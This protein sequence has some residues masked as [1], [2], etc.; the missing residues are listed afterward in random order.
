MQT[1]YEFVKLISGYAVARRPHGEIE[2]VY[3]SYV[4]A[5]RAACEMSGR[6]SDAVA[7]RDRVPLSINQSPT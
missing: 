7:L 2:G 6:G 1:K 5:E 4:E 3:D